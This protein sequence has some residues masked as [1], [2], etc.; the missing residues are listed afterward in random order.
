MHVHSKLRHAVKNAA[1]GDVVDMFL[2]EDC[3][4]RPLGQAPYAF[5]RKSTT[6]YPDFCAYGVQ[7]T[8][9]VFNAGF[10]G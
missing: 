2:P 5:A 4:G 8:D 1:S 10:D 7:E 9:I 6:G 3:R